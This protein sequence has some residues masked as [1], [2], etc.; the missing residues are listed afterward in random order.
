MLFWPARARVRSSCSKRRAELILDMSSPSSVR[1]DASWLCAK[2]Q[3]D[4]RLSSAQQ[5]SKS[6]ITPGFESTTLIEL[7]THCSSPPA[8]CETCTGR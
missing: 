4:K 8:G 1:R 7:I 3:L 5:Y 6:F 2:N